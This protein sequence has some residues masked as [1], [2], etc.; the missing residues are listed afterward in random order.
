MTP[1]ADREN[2]VRS[3]SL[4]AYSINASVVGSRHDTSS[5]SSSSSSLHGKI[6]LL[7]L[8]KEDRKLSKK[9]DCLSTKLNNVTNMVKKI[10]EK[11]HYQP[12]DVQTLVMKK[13]QIDV[14]LDWL[15]RM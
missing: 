7:F 14:L 11:L 8:Y 15:H 13:V 12:D 5:S 10:F 2:S 6:T 1:W 4:C 3:S 9:V